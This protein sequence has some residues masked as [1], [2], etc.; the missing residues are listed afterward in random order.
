MIMF[1]CRKR[2]DGLYRAFVLAYVPGFKILFISEKI[3]SNWIVLIEFA[4]INFLFWSFL[5]SQRNF[6]EQW[7]DIES[8]S[9][10]RPCYLYRDIVLYPLGNCC[11]SLVYTSR[12]Y[13]VQTGQC[14]LWN[15]NSE[16]FEFLDVISL[17]LVLI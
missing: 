9:I 7:E 4:G 6:G 13:V 2:M 11:G 1:A 14:Y 16:P 5:N 12:F 17:K 15:F 3:F 8:S 10:S